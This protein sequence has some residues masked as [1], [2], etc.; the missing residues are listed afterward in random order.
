LSA[1][2]VSALVLIDCRS[3]AIVRTA[4]DRLRTTKDIS[5][6]MTVSRY[7]PQLENIFLWAQM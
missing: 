4:I 6:S 2:N 7:L 1:G 5:Q 3:S